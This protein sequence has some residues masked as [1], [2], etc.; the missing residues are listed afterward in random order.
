MGAGGSFPGIKRAEI[1]VEW[2]SYTSTPPYFFI[3]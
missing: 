3:A 1:Y 2:W